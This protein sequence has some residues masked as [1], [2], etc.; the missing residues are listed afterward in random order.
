[1]TPEAF[2]EQLR[3]HRER[4]GFTLQQVAQETKIAGHVLAALERGD[5]ARWPGGIY[6]RGYVRAYAAAV[7]LDPEDVVERFCECYPQAARP[8]PE[9]PAP[10]RRAPRPLERIRAGLAAWL[11]VAAARR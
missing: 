6:S 1:V 4:R 8:R 2:G 5:C 11:R 10:P 3:R 7:G 9:D